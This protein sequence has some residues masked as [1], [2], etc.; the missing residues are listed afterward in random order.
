[1]LTL[2]LC[3]HLLLDLAQPIRQVLHSL[4]HFV[5]QTIKPAGRI[6]SLDVSILHEDLNSRQILLVLANLI[7]C[8]IHLVLQLRNR[9][10]LL[11]RV[12]GYLIDIGLKLHEE[13]LI[14]TLYDIL[15]PL[16]DSLLDE[17]GKCCDLQID[18]LIDERAHTIHNQVGCALH[19]VLNLLMDKLFKF[20]LQ[21]MANSLIVIALANS[22]SVIALAKSLPV[23]VIALA[24]TE[25]VHV[26][27]S[28]I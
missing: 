10:S 6:L 12:G 18:S 11:V 22:L 19:G 14:L 17:L 28:Q 21:Q 27:A 16:V 8:V 5:L 3:A 13:A 20:G 23:I 26:H 7:D 15:A 2:E 25:S 4:V 9:A 1:M 24:K